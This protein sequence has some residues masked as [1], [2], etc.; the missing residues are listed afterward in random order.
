MNKRLR[1]STRT[2]S[3]L[4]LASLYTAYALVFAQQSQNSRRKGIIVRAAKPYDRIENVIRGLGGYITYEYENVDAVA[5]SLPEDKLPSLSALAG[6][7][8]LYKDVSVRPPDPIDIPGHQPKKG[9]TLLKL[10]PQGATVLSEDDVAQIGAAS[11][12]AG[13]S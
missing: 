8:A 3:F 5:A 13:T 7:A 11:G 10:T 4:F 6:A 12:T 2:A 1:L 9:V